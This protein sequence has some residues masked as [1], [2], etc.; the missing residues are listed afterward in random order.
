MASEKIDILENTDLFSS[1]I[2]AI[3]K[4]K[5]T[6]RIPTAGGI[7]GAYEEVPMK[8]GVRALTD[9]RLF[10]TSQLS[11]ILGKF[12]LNYPEEDQFG[13]DLAGIIIKTHKDLETVLEGTHRLSLPIGDGQFLETLESILWA[14]EKYIF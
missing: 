2:D 5:S 3:K 1:I 11:E 13:I 12:N 10:S 6:I 7:P 4:K 14:K 8:E 9:R